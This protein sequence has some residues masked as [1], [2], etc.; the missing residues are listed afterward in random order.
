MAI[1]VEVK[2]K[3]ILGIYICIFTNH[4]IATINFNIIGVILGLVSPNRNCQ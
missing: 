4:F 1:M 3:N 2:I